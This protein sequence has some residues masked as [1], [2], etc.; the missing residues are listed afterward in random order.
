MQRIAAALALGFI[1]L[2]PATLHATP[3]DGTVER[4]LVAR[5]GDTL[6][7]L[8]NGAGA[9]PTG[10]AG[11]IAALRPLFPPRGL[12]VGQEVA[13][14]LDPR[15][16]DALVAVEI[17]PTPGRT[18]HAAL[19]DGRW[20]AREEAATQ[21]R[22]LAIAAG[23][24]DGGLYPAVTAAGLP[25][26]LALS[27]L[28]A[29]GHRVDF[30]R[31]L[32]PGDRFAILFER[33]RDDQGAMLGHGRVL[34]VELLLSGRRHAWWRFDTADGTEWY[35]E[36]GE[37][38]RRAFLRTPL[39]GARVS[40]GF[41]LR[42]HPML[43]YSRMHRGTDFAAPSGTP[44]YAA[45]DGTVAAARVERGYGRIVRLSHGD[46][47]ETR[48]AHLSRFARGLGTGQR[49]RQGDVIGR[50]GS[51][52]LSTGPHLH[53]EIVLGGQAVDPARQPAQATRLSGDEWQAFQAARARLATAL[54]QMGQRT[55][56]ALAD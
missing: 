45:A 51:T 16:D 27:L 28:R 49:V 24:I 48:Y 36:Q 38:L 32:H 7:E 3:A 25:P 18:I 21:H 1:S 22:H 33:F 54:A 39:D 55:E 46:G 40:S 8:L 2:V 31:D 15:R 53:F 20:Q 43:G 14:R 30:Q 11:A 10:I 34:Q 42:S 13:I 52:G 56:I 12:R 4:V 6:T 44:V 9:E 26:G 23:A 5:R 50:V 41:G 37:A 29:L 19:Q 35:D 47:V 17:E